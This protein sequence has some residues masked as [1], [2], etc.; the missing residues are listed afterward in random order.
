M[1]IQ[2]WMAVD[3]V[4][5]AVTYVLGCCN[6][7]TWPQNRRPMCPCCRTEDNRKQQHCIQGAPSVFGAFTSSLAR[8]PTDKKVI[9]PVELSQFCD[10]QVKNGT[11]WVAKI[12]SSID[13][14]FVQHMHKR[15]ATAKAPPPP[16]G[17]GARQVTFS[18]PDPSG[19]Y[20][21][22][23]C[24]YRGAA[25]HKAPPPEAATYKAPPP[26]S[27]W[28]APVA[29]LPLVVPSN[30]N[31]DFV[32]PPHA[33]RPERDVPRPPPLQVA[34]AKPR[35]PMPPPDTP[36]ASSYVDN[37]GQG[38]LNVGTQPNNDP[39]GLSCTSR[40]QMMPGFHLYQLNIS[41]MNTAMAHEDLRGDMAIMR[42]TNSPDRLVLT[43]EHTWLVGE[44]LVHKVGMIFELDYVSVAPFNL[45]NEDNTRRGQTGKFLCQWHCQCFDPSQ[46]DEW[47]TFTVDPQG[48]RDAANQREPHPMAS[49]ATFGGT[50][51]QGDQ[52]RAHITT[53]AVADD[54][55]MKRR[56]H[57][58]THGY[59]IADRI[60][61]TFQDTNGGILYFEVSFSQNI[62][63]F[64]N[65]VKIV[66]NRNQQICALGEPAFR[67]EETLAV[68]DTTSAH[69]NCAALRFQL[70]SVGCRMSCQVC[71]LENVVVRGC[72]DPQM[73][74][75]IMNEVANTGHTV[76][77][78]PPISRADADWIT[79]NAAPQFQSGEPI[80]RNTYDA[81]QWH[82]VLGGPTK[83]RDAD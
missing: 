80:L 34:K 75:A 10:Y 16:P 2:F 23:L 15:T 46:E 50:T 18:A 68:V 13:T 7:G 60:V 35:P 56:K 42:P 3:E 27:S 6:T 52:T 5:P 74:R 83:T 63:H 17:Q 48:D 70:N 38:H 58:A 39:R 12:Y 71:S 69:I 8:F 20:R 40:R 37:M 45:G 66:R 81:A 33:P 62:P 61:V 11:A 25:T 65:S 44:N 43:W 28:R 31:Q 49:V 21:G 57:A 29:V 24:N 73:R 9:F 54:V 19:P 77:T 53:S 67:C 14:F 78:P 82:R 32:P 36:M 22:D 30:L 41:Q 64:D 1:V 59:G 47:S 79:G 26:E 76:V 51:H 55:M 4:C 72:E